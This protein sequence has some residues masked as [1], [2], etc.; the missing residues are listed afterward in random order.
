MVACKG[1]RW[2]PRDYGTKAYKDFDESEK[3]GV[4]SFEGAL[5]YSANLNKPLLAS[6]NPLQLAASAV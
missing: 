6:Y 1:K 5:S 2:L 4:E 3:A